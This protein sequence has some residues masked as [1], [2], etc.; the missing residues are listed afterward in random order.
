MNLTGEDY[1]AQGNERMK[2][3]KTY[4][5]ERGYKQIGV[6]LSEHNR[7]LIETLKKEH[8][9]NTQQTFEHIFIKYETAINNANKIVINDVNKNKEVKPQ[10]TILESSPSRNLEQ[11]E[12][13]PQK[14]TVAELDQLILELHE[15]FQSNQERIDYLNSSGIM[16]PTRTGFDFWTIKTLRSYVGNIVHRQK[17]NSKQTKL[18]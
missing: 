18:G 8:G 16:K 13:S 6:F 2:R 11:G 4:Q 14:L 5:A 12:S 3:F 17:K 1:R 9:W 15:R 7:N 10:K